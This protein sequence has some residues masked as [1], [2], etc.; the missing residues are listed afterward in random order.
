MKKQE[1]WRGLTRYGYTWHAV[2]EKGAMVTLCRHILKEPSR[3][4]GEVECRR[5]LRALRRSDDANS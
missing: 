3:E 4:R 2:R 1:A 5:C